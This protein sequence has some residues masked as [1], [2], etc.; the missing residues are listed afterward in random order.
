[1]KILNY[2]NQNEKA[3]ICYKRNCLTVSGESAKI[4][5]SIAVVI[6]VIALVAIM[7]EVFE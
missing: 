4:V 3:T 2:N 5:N 7:K 1:M 6:S